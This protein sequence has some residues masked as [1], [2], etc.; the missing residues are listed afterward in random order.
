MTNSE[1]DRKRLVGTP[2]YDNWRAYNDGEPSLGGYEYVLHSDANMVGEVP[3]L[4]PYSFINLVPYERQPGRVKTAVGLRGSV[5]AQLDGPPMETTDYT[6]YHG[7]DASDELAALASLLCGARFRAGNQTR[8]FDA[9]GDPAGRPVAWGTR[10]DPVLSISVRGFVL[11]HVAGIGSQLSLMPLEELVTFPRLQP[12]EAIT[13]VRAARLYQDAL[14]LAESEPNL[15]WLLLVSALETAANRWRAGN[16]SAIDRLRVSRPAFVSFMESRSNSEVLEKVAA[17]FAGSI[18]STKKFVD[19]LLA[20]MPEA[21]SVRPEEWG[22]VNWSE[23]SL[24]DTFRMIYGYRSRALH[25]GMPFPAPMT[26][27]PY[28]YESWKAVAEKPIG[29]AQSSGGGT[30]R[31]EDTPMLLHTFE[32]IA[33]NALTTWWK[34][35]VPAAN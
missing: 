5:H 18:G 3:G 22:Q 30:W 28:R 1:P 35:L 11:P 33:R 34:S 29:L 19:F 9:G 10:P 12:D 15:S 25:D 16:D 14:W 23:G 6:R 24:R 20:F 27:P 8:R 7:G 17:E 32:Y 13:L 26:E 2:V 31:A 21:P 4:G